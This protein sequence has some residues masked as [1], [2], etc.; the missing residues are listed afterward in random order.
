MWPAWYMAWKKSVII[1]PLYSVTKAGLD[2][3]EV[4]EWQ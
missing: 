2:A 3:E 4:Q 1:A